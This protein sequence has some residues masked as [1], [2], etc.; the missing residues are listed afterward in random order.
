MI[1]YS[2]NDDIN[3]NK[4]ARFKNDLTLKLFIN[5][6][7]VNN[8]SVYPNN[9]IED[10]N[11]NYYI[12]NKTNLLELQNKFLEFDNTKRTIKLIFD[13]KNYTKEMNSFRKCILK[14]YFYKNSSIKIPN[15][16]HIKILYEI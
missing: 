11:N 5:R 12:T 6:G 9:L 2:C 8:V 3:V 16:I 14:K 1:E 13:K 7:G 10:L 15:N 4:I